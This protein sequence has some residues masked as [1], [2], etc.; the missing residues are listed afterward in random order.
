MT[1]WAVLSITPLMKMV[2]AIAS[3]SGQ[4]DGGG[5]WIA[6]IDSLVGAGGRGVGWPPWPSPCFCSQRS[7]RPWE[8]GSTAKLYTGGGEGML[9]SSVRA[10]HGSGPATAPERCVLKAL[11]MN[12]RIDSAM[13]NAPIDDTMF[14]KFHPRSGA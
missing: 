10:S 3:R 5:M 2:T 12:T 8:V 9:H 13:M 1:I 7:S 11:T 6:A 14:Q 4:Y